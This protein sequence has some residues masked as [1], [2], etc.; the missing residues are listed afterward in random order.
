MI[1]LGGFAWG[2]GGGALDVPNWSLFVLRF[3]AGREIIGRAGAGGVCC[4][5]WG[6]PGRGLGRG[7]WDFSNRNPAYC[8]SRILVPGGKELLDG[9]AL[10][11]F[12]SCFGVNLGV[13]VGCGTRGL[14][15][16]NQR[17]TSV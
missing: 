11:E 1:L 16:R 3:R 10:E 6:E 5:L 17:S 9:P 7:A 14:S 13:G 8:P 4:L 2:L 12:A 15:N